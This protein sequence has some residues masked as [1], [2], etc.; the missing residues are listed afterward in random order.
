MRTPTL[1][2]DPGRLRDEAERM[3]SGAIKLPQ[4][5]AMRTRLFALATEL[6][7][8]AYAIERMPPEQ[9]A[10]LIEMLRAV[11]SQ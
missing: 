9:R 10:D 3:R 11:R 4:G 8:T 1:A 2:E 5:D 6:D 7:E